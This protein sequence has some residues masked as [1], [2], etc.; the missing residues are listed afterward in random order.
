MNQMEYNRRKGKKK[1]VKNEPISEKEKREKFVKSMN[2]FRSKL[3]TWAPEEMKMCEC[4]HFINKTVGKP[5][6]KTT[7]IEAGYYPN[8]ETVTKIYNKI[9]AC[10]K[11]LK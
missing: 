2:E 9:K 7:L 11:Y 4:F 3:S 8:D 6:I 10:V 5:F 1:E